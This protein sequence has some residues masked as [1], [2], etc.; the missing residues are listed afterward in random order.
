LT[1]SGESAPRAAV[2]GFIPRRDPNAERH[3]SFANSLAFA[4]Q[5]LVRSKYSVISSVLSD[6]TIVSID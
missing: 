4:R 3:L 6:S 2:C 1:R 5:P